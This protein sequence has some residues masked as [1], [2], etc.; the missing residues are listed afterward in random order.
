MSKKFGYWKKYY[1]QN[2]RKL[3]AKSYE[4]RNNNPEKVRE[5]QINYRIK[6]K[7][8]ENEASKR[9]YKQWVGIE[10]NHQHKKEY[11]KRWFLKNSK[12]IKE[13]RAKLNSLLQTLRSGKAKINGYDVEVKQDKGGK[14]FYF[15]C[16]N[17]RL[18]YM[19]DKFITKVDAVKDLEY[20]L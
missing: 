3:K 4:W 11:Q 9:R 16:Q 14:W 2:K 15:L 18:V 17:K 7:E 8:K 5:Y 10:Q 6:N 12:F 20:A 1:K 13:E 19:S